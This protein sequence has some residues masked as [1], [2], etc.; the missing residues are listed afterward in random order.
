MKPEIQE[1]TNSDLSAAPLFTRVDME[2]VHKRMNS[3]LLPSR[4]DEI[5]RAAPSPEV[6]KAWL[7]I[8]NESPIAITKEEVIQLGKDPSTRV[9]YPP[10]FGLGEEVYAGRLDI[11]H[12]IHCLDALRR[13]AYWD[14]YYG[15][16]YESYEATPK[17]HKAHLSHCIYYLLQ[18]I[19]CS[20]SLDVYTHVWTDALNTPFPDFNMTKK[21]RNFDAL[22]DYQERN[23][24][25]L[26]D[27]YAMRRPEE[28]GAPL[29]FSESFKD[30]WREFNSYNEEG[31][32]HH[33]DHIG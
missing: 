17:L 1:V 13:E 7:K 11:F 10:S 9:K 24:V 32:A 29:T 23:A 19:M 5:Y 15:K 4:E 2:M 18:N 27:F 20:A 3:T 25:K 28:Y 31:D 26:N 8:S 6:D 33:G 21:C 14:H 12:Q 16:K 30:L 22:L